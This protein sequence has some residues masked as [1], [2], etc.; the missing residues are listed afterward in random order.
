MC[1]SNIDGDG[2]QCIFIFNGEKVMIRAGCFFGTWEE[3]IEKT[4]TKGMETYCVIIKAIAEGIL[5]RFSGVDCGED[6]G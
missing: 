4:K 3:M 5:E 2:Y 6:N 1:A